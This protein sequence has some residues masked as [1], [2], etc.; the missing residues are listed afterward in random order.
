M[1]TC[2]ESGIEFDFS[3]ARTVCEH[4]MTTSKCYGVS[5]PDGNTG[6]PGVDFRVEDEYGWIWLEVKH[7]Q[8]RMRGSF[9]HKVQDKDYAAEMRGK[10]L[11]TTA[12]LAWN[13]MFT[14]APLRYVLLFEPPTSSDRYLLAPFQDLVRKEMNAAIKL[15]I[16]VL[17]MSIDSWNDVFDRFPARKRR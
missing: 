3:L 16:R 9:A 11:G 13:G 2:I 5:H 12:Y 7:W 6:W 8:G 1:P 15:K 14:P 10:F 4:D 17:V